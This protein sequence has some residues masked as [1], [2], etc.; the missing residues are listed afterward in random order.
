MIR[1]PILVQ[2][3]DMHNLDSSMS[4]T[5]KRAIL[6]IY[7]SILD[8]SHDTFLGHPNANISN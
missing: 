7:C 2:G 3:Y 5:Q 1:K 8:S 4:V 6:V